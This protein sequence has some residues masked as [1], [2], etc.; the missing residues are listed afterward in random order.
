VLLLFIRSDCDVELL[1]SI[2][3]R[4]VFVAHRWRLA[5]RLAVM[6]TIIVVVLFS[7]IRFAIIISRFQIAR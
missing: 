1:S 7:R 4:L 5:A 3:V 2:V 6:S